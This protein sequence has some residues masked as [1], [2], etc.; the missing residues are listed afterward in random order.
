MRHNDTGREQTKVSC[1][2]EGRRLHRRKFLAVSVT[3]GLGTV[4]FP[5]SA[6]VG[7]DG[8]GEAVRFGI[9][10]D[11]HYADV[12]PRG[13]R[14]YRESLC[15]MEECV[16]VMNREEVD[17]LIELGDLKDQDKSPKEEK[18]LSYLRTIEG[19][20]Q[21]FDGPTYHVPGNHDFDSLSKEQFLSAVENTGVDEGSTYYSF[22]AEGLHCIVLD[23]NFR[24]DGTPYDHGNFGWTD[25]NIPPEELEW[26]E[27]DLGAADSPAVVFIH[28]Q[29]LGHDAHTVNNAD[30]V[31]SL[32]GASGKVRAVFQGHYH[33]G[34]YAEKDGIHYYTLRAMVDGSGEE[35]NAYGVVGAGSDSIVVTGLRKAASQV[36]P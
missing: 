20:F 19:A 30:R 33:P 10:T 5:S 24:A 35:Q 16:D 32:L 25:A 34:D 36:M 9:V 7:S 23:A 29:L 8:G 4:L 14:Y 11:S 27:S 1:A 26:L 3:V 28:Q 18:T 15:K 17:F 6:L 31:R 22:D 12:P 2:G 13:N 21:E